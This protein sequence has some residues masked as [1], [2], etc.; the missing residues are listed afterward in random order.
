MEE[1]SL[2]PAMEDYIETIYLLEEKNKVARVSEIGRSMKVRKASVVSAVSNL[3]KQNMI[4]HEK[5]GFI[6]LTP[7]GRETAEKIYKKHKII[8]EFLES[9]LKVEPERALEEACGIEHALSAGTVDK[10][11]VFVKQFKTAPEK[12]ETKNRKTKKN[13]D[14]KKKTF[15]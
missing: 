6:T 15:K 10:L 1:N 14:T 11:S 8:L 2:T 7:F 12:N 9:I 5:Y 4:E 13:A 3:Q